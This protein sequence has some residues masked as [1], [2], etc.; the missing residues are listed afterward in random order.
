MFCEGNRVPAEPRVCIV[1]DDESLR[2][3]LV[4][5]LRSLDYQAEG[6]GSAEQYLARSASEPHAC[7]IT[8]IHLPEL[9]GIELVQRLRRG[10]NQVAVIMITARSEPML[11]EQA[12][13]TGASCLLKKPFEAD[14]LIAC[15]ERVLKTDRA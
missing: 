4:S 12:M 7:L 5:L 2:V 3:A 6:F 11:E 15:L 9:S 1:E 8:D 14:A 10:G 13:A